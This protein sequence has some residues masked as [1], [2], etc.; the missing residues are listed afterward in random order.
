MSV[1]LLRSSSL[2]CEIKE[3]FGHFG[4]YELVI[5]ERGCNFEVKKEHVNIYWCKNEK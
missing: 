3:D 1:F 4:I 2:I 5:D